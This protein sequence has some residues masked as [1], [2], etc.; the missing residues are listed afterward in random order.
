MMEQAKGL[1]KGFD[2]KWTDEA[3]W[4]AEVG[5]A[6]PPFSQGATDRGF[7]GLT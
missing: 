3:K 5:R 2:A 6:P 1:Q 7:R 4:G